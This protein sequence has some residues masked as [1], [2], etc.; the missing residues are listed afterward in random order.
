MIEGMDQSELVLLKFTHEESQTKLRW[1]HSREFEYDGEMYD[2]VEKEES[3]DTISYWCWWD[4]EETQLNRKLRDLVADAMGHHPLNKERQER[5]THFL[6]NLYC[7]Y[8]FEKPAIAHSLCRIL[9]LK[10]HI[11]YSSIYFSPPSPP[12]EFL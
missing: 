1:V 9:P 11:G 12:P 5:L 8:N 6:E 3:G 7:Q 2:I 10:S 4:Y